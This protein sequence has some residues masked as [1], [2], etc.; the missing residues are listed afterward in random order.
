MFSFAWPWFALL[1]PLPW[2]VRRWAASRGVRTSEQQTSVLL[3]PGVATLQN[4]F[5]SL[6][7]VSG[8]ASLMQSLLLGLLWASLVV[9]MMRPEWLEE[10]TQVVSPGYDLILDPWRP[11]TS[12]WTAGV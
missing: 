1:L 3:H 8:L 4:A 10:H 7:P 6:S 2:V 12:R 9:A 11:W 5:V